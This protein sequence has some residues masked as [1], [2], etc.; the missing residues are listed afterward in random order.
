M[1]G[2]Y[3]PLEVIVIKP[4]EVEMILIKEMLEGLGKLYC[5]TV[6]CKE[7]KVG[8]KVFETGEE[9]DSVYKI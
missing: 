5:P 8:Y 1:I 6:E 4:E 2:M 3:D 9:V 7:P